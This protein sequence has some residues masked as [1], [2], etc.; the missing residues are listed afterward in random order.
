MHEDDKKILGGVA[1]G[2]GGGF[3]GTKAVVALSP[4]IALTGPFAPFIA[5]GMIGASAAIGAKSGSKDPAGGALT[6][7]AGVAGI[8]LP[9]KDNLV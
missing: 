7:I 5:L 3:I 9:G 1:G 4:L 6:G 2:V 8:P